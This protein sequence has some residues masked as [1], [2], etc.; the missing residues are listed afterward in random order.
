MQYDI[1]IPHHQLARIT[2]GQTTCGLVAVN[3]HKFDPLMDVSTNQRF[4]SVPA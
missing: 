2:P 1:C 4:L 3:G